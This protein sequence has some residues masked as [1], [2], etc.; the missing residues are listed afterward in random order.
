MIVPNLYSISNSKGTIPAPIE[1]YQPK[2]VDGYFG[3][4]TL[5]Y[6][7]FLSLDGTLRRDKSSTLPADA[8]AYNY[9]AISGSYLFSYHLPNAKWISS[10]KVRANY[11]TVGNDAPWGSITDVY[12]KPNPFGST[13]LFSLPPTKNNSNLK[14]ENT[15]SKEVGLEMAFI[16]NRLGFEA[17]YYHTN[18]VDQ[19]IPVAVSAGTGYTSK[20]INAGNIENKGIELSLYGAPVRK[21][22][23]NWN[24]NIN[25]TRNRNEV[26]SLYNESKNL[27]LGSFQGGVSLNASIGKPYGELQAISYQML[28]G[29]RIV[30]DNGLYLLT[31]TTSNVIG[32]INPD[33]IGGMNNSFRYKNLTLSFL[34]DVRKGG[35][36]FSLDM[37][38]GQA[39]GILPESVGLNDLGNPVRD[40]VANGGGIILPGVT[41]DGK[42]NTKRV[43][44]TSNNSYVYPQSQ[45]SYDASY[46]KLR[47]VAFSYSLP[48]KLISKIAKEIELSLIGRNLWLIYKNVPYADGGQCW[49]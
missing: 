10:G 42:P 20:F 17:S 4:I 43:T 5:S 38:Y 34:I 30:K 11:A 21:N 35:D 32:N 16:K 36:L 1:T 33:W 19:I 24:M 44:I 27:Q 29:Q 49:W 9:Y 45:F 3:G 12:D 25:Y 6:K 37:Y 26:L 23:F 14:P 41:A 46:V 13:L 28:D 48:K 40:A 22:N 31:T 18:T 2:A 15:I 7:E 8:N 47:E 39:S